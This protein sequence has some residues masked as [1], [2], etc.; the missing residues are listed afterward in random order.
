MKK[1]IGWAQLCA[2]ARDRWQ[3]HPTDSGADWKESIKRRVTRLGYLGPTSEQVHKAMDAV[4][5]TLPRRQTQPTPTI[6]PEQ[7][8]DPTVNRTKA[9][10]VASALS[11]AT[12]VPLPAFLQKP[13]SGS[14]GS[15]SGSPRPTI[16]LT[17]PGW[18][19]IDGKV[20][21]VRTGEHADD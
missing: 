10:Q 7:P 12:G 3:E 8:A 13:S 19:V 5:R 18:V 20:Q 21:R 14:A 15:R 2:I 1:T 11:R 17:S 4:E 9:G 16:V 6:E